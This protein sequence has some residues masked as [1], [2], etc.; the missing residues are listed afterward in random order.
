MARKQLRL[1]ATHESAISDVTITKSCFSPVLVRAPMRKTAVVFVVTCFFSLGVCQSA[2][3]IKVSHSVDG[4]LIDDGFEAN[5]PGDHPFDWTVRDISGG[6]IQVVTA[7]LGGPPAPPAAEGANSLAI[8]SAF[9]LPG[10][11]SAP[12]ATAYTSGVI[13]AEFSFNLSHID[14]STLYVTFRHDDEL[15]LFGAEHWVGFG[16]AGYVNRYGGTSLSADQ[17]GMLYYPGSGSDIALTAGGAVFSYDLNTW[18][19]VRLTY[20]ISALKLNIEVNGVVL[21]PL[22][23]PSTIAQGLVTG[24]AATSNDAGLAYLDSIGTSPPVQPGDFDGDGD[25]D[26]DDLTHS[27]LG[28]KSR[29]GVD[30]DGNDF[31]TW[32]REFG[33]GIAAS[34]GASAAVP[35]PN[36]IP[37]AVL[38]VLGL[39]AVRRKRIGRN[40]FRL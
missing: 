17:G 35:E 7:G 25:V 13:K 14:R 23:A 39:A 15:L 20:D 36:A 10:I 22:P 32:Q 40:P 27:T 12:F 26:G 24:I 9:G 30:L 18:N 6:D 4:V 2:F 5:S 38:S 19:N 1:K 37:L 33:S 16:N 21:D 8:Q 3:A 31:L 11:Y 28:W 29:F 34:L